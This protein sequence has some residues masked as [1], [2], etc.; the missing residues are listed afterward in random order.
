MAVALGLSFSLSLSR[1]FAVE[2]I[3][4]REPL[5]KPLQYC[6]CFGRHTSVVTVTLGFLPSACDM[7]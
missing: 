4:V 7:N 1:L 6:L 2:I 3:R 5:T